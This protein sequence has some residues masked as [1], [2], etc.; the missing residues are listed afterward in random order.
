MR[1]DS[2]T[3]TTCALSTPFPIAGLSRYDEIDYVH[4]AFLKRVSRWQ[5]QGVLT[6][7][8]SWQHAWNLFVHVYNFHAVK[9]ELQEGKE[10]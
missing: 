4:A 6:G 7:D 9:N 2:S 5:G 8:E 1:W 3:E 10:D